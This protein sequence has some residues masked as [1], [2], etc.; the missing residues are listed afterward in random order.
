MRYL[1]FLGALTLGG[2]RG[3]KNN[4]K[5]GKGEVEVLALG[6]HV[7]RYGEHSM[8]AKFQQTRCQG[9]SARAWAH[10]WSS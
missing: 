9:P 8:L 1:A 7:H 5:R 10:D 2:G 6:T 3:E 4:T